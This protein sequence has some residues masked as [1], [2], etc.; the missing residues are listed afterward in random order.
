MLELRNLSAGYD[1][2]PTIQEISLTVA[3]GQITTI[4][5][6]NGCGKTTL[7]R[8]IARLLNVHSGEILLDGQ[9]LQG[10]DRR[11]LARKLSYLPQIKQSSPISVQTLVL[12]GRFPHLSFPRRV[13]A[14]DCAIAEQAMQEIGIWDLRDKD[15]TELSGGERQKAYI[16]MALA[17][18]ADI[19]LLDEPT[20]YLDI[21]HQLEIY[22]IV[23]KLKRLGKTI[24]MVVHDL[25]AALRHSDRI[26]LMADGRIVMHDTTAAVIDSGRI[27]QVFQ[28]QIEQW[29]RPGSQPAY[30]VE[31]AGF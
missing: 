4:L 30:I 21:N 19:I 17:Q 5:G 6:K 28:I 11:E 25:P 13:S 20:A 26:C 22:R 7:L 9:D 18:D 14:R 2:K 15:L 8:T 27:E 1:G 24:V 10:Y 3:E 31:K 29:R 12:H 23:E 16:A